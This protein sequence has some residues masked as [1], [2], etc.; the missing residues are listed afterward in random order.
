MIAFLKIFVHNYIKAY[1]HDIYVNRNLFHMYVHFFLQKHIFESSS[2][3]YVI[4]IYTKIFN[5]ANNKM[6]FAL[7]KISVHIY[8]PN[9]SKNGNNEREQYV[10]ESIRYN[11]YRIGILKTTYENR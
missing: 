2:Y 11:Y 3:I 6:M 10:V 7:L 9:F 8:E 1:E 4:Y 5:A